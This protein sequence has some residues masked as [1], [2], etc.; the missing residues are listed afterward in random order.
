M[1]RKHKRTIAFLALFLLLVLASLACARAGQILPDAEATELA[2]PTAT[3]VLDLSAEAEYQIGETADVV[4]GSFGALVPLYGQPGGRFFTSQIRNRDLVVI[5]EL[6]LD[7]NGNIW[8]LVEGQAGK[9][10][11][12]GENLTQPDLSV[13]E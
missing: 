5:L 10:W 6:G 8:Y 4:G 12:R 13:T 11:I 1:T 9:G 3:P 7:E 2:R